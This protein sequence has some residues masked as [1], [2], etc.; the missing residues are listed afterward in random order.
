MSASFKLI[1]VGVLAALVLGCS[2][3]NP[4]TLANKLAVPVSVLFD[5][6]A[7]ILEPGRSEKFRG[8]NFGFALESEGERITFFPIPELVGYP[9]D[10]VCGFRSKIEME[11]R[12]VGEVAVLPCDKD[13]P[14]LVLSGKQETGNHEA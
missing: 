9:A 1:V 14:P 2:Y 10:Y 5:G 12:S 7:T 13:G 3:A 4:V 11:V 8:L 6:T